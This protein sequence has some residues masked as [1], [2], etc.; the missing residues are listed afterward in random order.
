HLGRSGGD[1]LVRRPSRHGRGGGRG[2]GR[3]PGGHLVS[4]K[5]SLQAP[6]LLFLSPHRHRR[7]NPARPGRC[8]L[9]RLVPEPA[10][11][12]GGSR[13]NPRRM[14]WLL[15]L[16]LPVKPP[17]AFG[18]YRLLERISIGGMAEIW[19]AEV[20]PPQPELPPIVAIK[21]ILPSVDEDPDCV[22]MFM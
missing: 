3:G 15:S 9:R 4:S 10:R 11:R 2:G 20:Y 8:A 1:R 13:A 16:N 14:N 6:E 17:I 22:A 7:G 18:K 21:R 5:P 12:L 19:R